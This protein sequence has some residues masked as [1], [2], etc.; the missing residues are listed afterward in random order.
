MPLTKDTISGGVP[1]TIPRTN[2]KWEETYV[3][4]FEK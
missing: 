2:N 1:I 4:Y 3:Y